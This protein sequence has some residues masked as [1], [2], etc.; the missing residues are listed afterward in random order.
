MVIL[1]ALLVLV[2]VMVM[3]M[4]TVQWARTKHV[5]N[6]VFFIG[7]PMTKILFYTCVSGRDRL[8]P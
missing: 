3:V 6:D 5:Q 2:M 4:V 8:I 1:V 7:K